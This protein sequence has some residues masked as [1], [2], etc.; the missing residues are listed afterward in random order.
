MF[1]GV[2]GRLLQVAP[3]GRV[4]TASCNMKLLAQFGQER[5]TLVPACEI[6]RA[7]GNTTVTFPLMKLTGRAFAPASETS[8]GTGRS[9]KA[10]EKPP[11]PAGAAWK[12]T[13]ISSFVPAGKTAPVLT[14][15]AK[16]R[17]P[18]AAWLEFT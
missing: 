3:G 18:E 9:P 2:T 10:A 5:T 16:P 15:S 12:V 7:G 6:S 8:R 1:I 14:A 17:R 11:E 4:A 13:R